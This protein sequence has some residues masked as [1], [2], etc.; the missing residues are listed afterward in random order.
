MINSFN[1]KREVF[2]MDDFKKNRH[3][4]QKQ[5]ITYFVNDYNRVDQ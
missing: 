4:Q 5:K 2:A 3:L 1:I